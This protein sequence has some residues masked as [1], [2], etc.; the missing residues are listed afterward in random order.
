MD[1][2]ELKEKLLQFHNY[3]FSSFDDPIIWFSKLAEKRDKFLKLKYTDLHT[4][5]SNMTIKNIKLF[6]KNNKN[7]L[8]LYISIIILLDQVSR[9][10]YRGSCKAYKY[11]KKCLSIAKHL[12]KVHNMVDIHLRYKKHNKMLYYYYFWVI[13]Y[14]HSE[15]IKEHDYIRNNIIT[16]INTTTNKDD[17]VKLKEM[18]YYL[19]EHTKI[20]KKYG[21]YPKRK[22][23]C[24]IPITD[25]EKYYIENS[26]TEMPF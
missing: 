3:W 23:Y 22:L 16:R 20:L 15:D 21:N 12:N 14:E 2:T 11:D 10:I 18:I 17:I 1:Y 9:Q 25:E 6:L 26:N 13:V 24:N 5:I 8:K 4:T 19:D 7:D